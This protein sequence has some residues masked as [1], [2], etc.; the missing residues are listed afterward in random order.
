MYP[1]SWSVIDEGPS[2]LILILIQCIC[3]SAEFPKL[4]YLYQLFSPLTQFYNWSHLAVK[5]TGDERFKRLLQ[6]YRVRD[7]ARRCIKAFE[8]YSYT[9]VS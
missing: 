2:D 9:Y 7:G 1:A 6:H 5:L 3:E 8:I 4:F